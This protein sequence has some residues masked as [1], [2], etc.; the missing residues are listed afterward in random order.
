MNS[1]LAI[2]Y[3]ASGRSLKPFDHLVIGYRGRLDAV[4]TSGRL[5]AVSGLRIKRSLENSC[6]GRT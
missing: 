4:S 1:W 2:L 6:K 5:L 3:S